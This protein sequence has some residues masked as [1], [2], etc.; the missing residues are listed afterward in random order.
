MFDCTCVNG[1]VWL[2]WPFLPLKLPFPP[3]KLS[4]PSLFKTIHFVLFSHKTQLARNKNNKINKKK[5]I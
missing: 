3:L 4:Y 2:F 1:G 5:I